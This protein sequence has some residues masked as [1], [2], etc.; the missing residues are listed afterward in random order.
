MRVTAAW[1]TAYAG[2]S[3]A[4]KGSFEH[5]ETGLSSLGGPALPEATQTTTDALELL[6]E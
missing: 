1:P 2:Y 5:N 4:I 6:S 3:I